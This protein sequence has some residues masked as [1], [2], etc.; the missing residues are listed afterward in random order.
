MTKINVR[1]IPNCTWILEGDSFYCTHDEVEIVTYYDDCIDIV[2]G[3]YYETM[4]EGYA[5]AECGA[6]LDG[7]LEDDQDYIAEEQLME[8]LTS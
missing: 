5:C 6:P 2:T 7:T 1:E 3:D 4:H 8:V